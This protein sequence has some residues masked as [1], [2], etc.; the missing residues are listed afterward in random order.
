M[1][2]HAYFRNKTITLSPKCILLIPHSDVKVWLRVFEINILQSPKVDLIFQI[3]GSLV[4]H[5]PVENKNIYVRE[6]TV[7]SSYLRI[8]E[9]KRF[10]REHS[11]VEGRVLRKE[12]TYSK[13]C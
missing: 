11:L 9:V 8:S 1:H 6:M 2:T 13:S 12:K 3:H 7:L 4:F 5:T 10:D